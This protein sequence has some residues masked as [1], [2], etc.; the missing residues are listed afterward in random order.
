[1]GFITA[2]IFTTILVI[3]VTIGSPFILSLIGLGQAGPIA[4]GLFS[5]AQGSG[6]A[7]G[8]WMAAAQAIAMA[9][10]SPTP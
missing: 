8:S 9:S 1:M 5:A 7:I 6:I 2:S 3:G 10:V 4:G